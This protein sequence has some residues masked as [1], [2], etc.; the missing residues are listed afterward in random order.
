[1][2]LSS[3]SY[4]PPSLRARITLGFTASFAAFV[5]VVCITALLWARHAAQIDAEERVR[6]AA[7]L[8]K[9][10][11]EGDAAEKSVARAFEEAH[12]DARLENISVLIIDNEGSTLGAS[13]HPSPPW[14]DPHHEWL[15]AKEQANKAT[16]VAG[17]NLRGMQTGLRRLAL[18]LLVLGLLLIGGAA[19]S[20][21]IL[22]GRTLQ[23]IDA[24]SDQADSASANPL[25]ARLSSPS[26]DAEVRHLVATLNAFLERLR[27][28][29]RAREQFYASAAH[30]LRTPLTVLSASIEVALSRPRENTE[31]RET[32][33]DLQSQ[34]R[35]LSK[36][37]EGL[38]TLNRLDMLRETDEDKEVIDLADLC[39][40]AMRSL[41]SITSKRNLTFETDFDTPCAVLAPPTYLTI[42]IRNLIENALLYATAGS[43]VSISLCPV[44]RGVRLRVSND[45]SDRESLDFARLFEPF[46]RADAS[47][48]RETGGNGLGLAICKAIADANGWQLLLNKTALGVEAEVLFS[49]IDGNLRDE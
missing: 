8:V 41:T 45:Y 5:L 37:T 21:W 22:V 4:V 44:P 12:E 29:T 15:I 16:I 9:L 27:E 35:R 47:R 28:N 40:L 31:Y 33:A 25:H 6:A 7:R 1:M 43:R 18:I 48:T 23:P 46:Y 38:L 26:E 13:R 34:T 36:L 17:F 14:P 20:A 24:L 19:A 49:P 3:H 2:Q 11:W 30:E 42:L 32:L 39:T 10:E